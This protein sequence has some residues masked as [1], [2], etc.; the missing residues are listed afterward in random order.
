MALLL[1]K[2]SIIGRH[3]DRHPVAGQRLDPVLLHFAR[4]IGNDLVAG[5]E[6]DAIASIGKDF[7]DQSFELDQFFFSHGS[8]KVE[9]RLAGPL[10]A[11]GVVVRTVFAVQESNTLDPFGLAAAMR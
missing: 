3:L 10:A 6:L 4:G 8:L 9:R 7:G 11:V 5:V 2:T 1:L